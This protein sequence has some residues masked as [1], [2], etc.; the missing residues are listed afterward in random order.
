MIEL[1]P[2]VQ[3]C[4]AKHCPPSFRILQG[5]EMDTDHDL[6]LALLVRRPT[7]WLVPG[8]WQNLDCWPQ[9]S[10]CRTGWM[11][12]RLEIKSHRES[13][14]MYTWSVVNKIFIPVIGTMKLP[15]CHKA[16]SGS[17]A[18]FRDGNMLPLPMC[19]TCPTAIRLN[20]KGCFKCLSVAS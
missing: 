18:S 14:T 9:S 11:I 8:G 3:Q 10:W 16:S 17:L 5:L 1:C 6:A 7:G 15:D 13:C 2:S 20:F 4:S 12:R 19:A